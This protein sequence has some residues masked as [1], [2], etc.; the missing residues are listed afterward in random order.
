MYQ[1]QAMMMQP[2]MMVQQPMYVQQQPMMMQQQGYQQQSNGMATRNGVAIQA[3]DGSMLQANAGDGGK[4]EAASIKDK[5]KTVNTTKAARDGEFIMASL[6]AKRT[7]LQDLRA[8]YGSGAK[9]FAKALDKYIDENFRNPKPV[10]EGFVAISEKSIMMY[11]AK[12]KLRRKKKK[13]K[14]DPKDVEVEVMEGA[15]MRIMRRGQIKDISV[16]KPPPLLTEEDA[17]CGGLCFCLPSGIIETEQDVR[18]KTYI[19]KLCEEGQRPDTED[20]QTEE[21]R[22]LTKITFKL[23]EPAKSG[24]FTGQSYV[25]L[26]NVANGPELLK[27]FEEWWM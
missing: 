18:K 10:P 14:V 3:A 23:A 22:G 17:P 11:K 13:N 16:I 21:Y 6:A 15:S 7:P 25:I 2:G 8:L 1:Q 19:Y 9:V 12:E 20:I 27:K 4:T 24:P 26:D 5:T